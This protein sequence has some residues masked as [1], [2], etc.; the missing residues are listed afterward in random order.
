MLQKF[1]NGV[2]I[3]DFL[4]FNLI[5]IDGTQFTDMHVVNITNNFLGIKHNWILHTFRGLCVSVAFWHQKHPDV[6]L[7]PP[8]NNR[9]W[10]WPFLPPLLRTSATVV[11]SCAPRSLSLGQEC[12]KCPWWRH[13]METFSALL[14]LCAG[15]SP[16]P[17]N[18]PHKGQWR[19]A[20]M[21]SLI[22]ALINDWVNNREAGDLRRY[23]GHYDVNVM[24]IA[25]C[26]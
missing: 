3:P 5:A 15:N 12:L 11:G 10:V 2:V 21:F 22:C 13:Q 6:R 26:I 14:A 18:S 7:G 4:F 8:P 23:H 19:G 20:L 16:V 25:H 9:A 1:I 24:Q 17:V